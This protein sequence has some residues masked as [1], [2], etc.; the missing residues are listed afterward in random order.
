MQSAPQQTLWARAEPIFTQNTDTHEHV[1][2]MLLYFCILPSEYKQCKVPLNKLCG[3]EQ[4]FPSHPL[5]VFASGRD[6]LNENQHDEEDGVDGDG[7]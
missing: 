4:S 6:T 2:P 7:E 5:L 1:L 3:H